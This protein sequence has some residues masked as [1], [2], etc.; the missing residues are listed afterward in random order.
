MNAPE[1]NEQI[2]SGI[3]DLE[4]HRFRWMSRS[5][6]VALK[7]PASALPL[8]VEFG[9]PDNAPGRRLTLRLDGREV[10]SEL[11]RGPGG[12]TLTTPPL[13]PAGASTTVQ[14]EVDRAFSVAGD[15]REL[16]IVLT[17]VGFR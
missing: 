6:V 14:I 4:D 3:Y 12:Y 7:S 13:H 10:A 15:R 1:A 8:R 9:I 11:Y 17:A 2:V 5:A 16:G